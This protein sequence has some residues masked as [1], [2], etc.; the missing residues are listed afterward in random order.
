MAS[1]RIGEKIKYVI[2]KSGNDPLSEAR[3]CVDCTSGATQ[4]S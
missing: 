2:S 4:S 3:R 1:Y